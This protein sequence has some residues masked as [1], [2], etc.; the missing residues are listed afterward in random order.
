MRR[1]EAAAESVTATR[2]REL[3]PS[4]P[5]QATLASRPCVAMAISDWLRFEPS[6]SKR[7]AARKRCPDGRTAT[8]LKTGP[9][10]PPSVS[11]C[12]LQAR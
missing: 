6:R 3:T 7:W 5:V 1:A 8:S 2:T 4:K 10:E 11:S 12:A 9:R